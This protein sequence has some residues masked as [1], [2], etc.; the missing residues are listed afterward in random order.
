MKKELEGKVAFV[1]GA[2]GGIGR[3]ICLELAKR[4][5]SLAITD[6]GLEDAR[7]TQRGLGELGQKAKSYK[8]DV[9]RKREVER[10]FGQV[11]REF[12]RLDILVNSAGIFSLNRIE[13]ISEKEWDRVLAVNL[14]GTFICSQ[15]AFRQM[16]LQGGGR[17]INLSSTAARLGGMAS[18][19]IYNPCTPYAASKA[20]IESLTRSMAY[21]GAP[22][23]ILVTA[24]A[25]G[26]I[27]TTMVDQYSSRRKKEFMGAIPMGRFGRPEGVAFAVAFL[28]SSRASYITAKILDINGGLLMD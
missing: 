23:G 6:I 3:S 15:A 17:I 19:G 11:I 8:L 22:H 21:E 9:T 25:P 16:K 5:A 14:K 10:V 24:V 4:G 12:G 20:A 2:G 18:P 27:E 1:T 13:A 26:P 28:A 7:K